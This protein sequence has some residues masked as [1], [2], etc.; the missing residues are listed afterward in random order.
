MIPMGRGEY[1]IPRDW[2]LETSH[3]PSSELLDWS[4]EFLGISDA[5]RD[6]EGT[7][8]SEPIKVCVLDTGCDLDHPDLDGAIIDASD[9]TKHNLNQRNQENREQ[10]LW[11]CLLELLRT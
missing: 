6:N 1:W 8:G 11:E 2:T 3:L 5:W 10:K 9:F 7:I 4:I